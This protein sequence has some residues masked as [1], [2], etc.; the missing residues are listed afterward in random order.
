M[1]YLTQPRT[2]TVNMAIGSAFHK[3]LEDGS[4]KYET[5][6]FDPIGDYTVAVIEQDAWRFEF[7]Q[8]VLDLVRQV[9]DA[10]AGV[11]EVRTS[12]TYQFRH[13]GVEVFSE[14]VIDSMIGYSL[15]EF[16]TKM[17]DKEP[18]DWTIETGRDNYRDSVQWRMYLDVT[19]AREVIYTIFYLQAEQE[20]GSNRVQVSGY[21]EPVQF[22]CEAYPTML[23]DVRSELESLIRFVQS[24]GLEDYLK[25]KEGTYG[26]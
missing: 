16:K 7:A 20:E 19:N 12:K 25:P 5:T 22:R 9:R 2:A 15:I 8:P 26:F 21:F 6:M 4:E 23:A 17:V 1:A 18:T 11:A 24:R 3:L 13:L 10:Y 14:M